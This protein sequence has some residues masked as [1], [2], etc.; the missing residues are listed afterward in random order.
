MRIFLMLKETDLPS[1]AIRGLSVQLENIRED[2]MEI[3]PIE[4]ITSCYRDN[5]AI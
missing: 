5:N 2:I 4:D 3:T 1:G